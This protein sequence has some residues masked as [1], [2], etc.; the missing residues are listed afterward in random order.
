MKARDSDGKLFII[1]F[2]S[3]YFPAVFIPAVMSGHKYTYLIHTVYNGTQCFPKERSF[4]EV[5]V[6]R[7]TTVR[8]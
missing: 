8:L 6:L 1:R 5:F 4:Y 2:F 7:S 3:C